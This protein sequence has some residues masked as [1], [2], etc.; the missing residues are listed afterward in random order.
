MVVL[1]TNLQ[2]LEK[3]VDR[4]NKDF[5]T[6]FKTEFKEVK[7]E[8]SGIASKLEKFLLQITNRATE[9]DGRID[10][11]KQEV[12]DKFKQLNGSIVFLRWAFFVVVIMGIVVGVWLQ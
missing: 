8:L 11:I 2:N 5:S 7:Q 4:T 12:S 1:E 3:N 9:Q 10:G 6:T